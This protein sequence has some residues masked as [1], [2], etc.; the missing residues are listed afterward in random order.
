MVTDEALRARHLALAAERPDASLAATLAAAGA[1]A[2]TRGAITDAVELAEHA[3][4]LT[5]ETTAERPDRLLALAEYLEIAGEYP[6]LAELLTGHADELP[7]GAPRA[8]SHLLLGKISEDLATHEAHLEHAWTESEGEPAL[9]AIVLATKS[10]MLLTRIERIRE[11]DA[12]AV[13]A[14]RLAGSE[15]YALYAL[16]WC[17]LARGRSLDD[18]TPRVPAAKYLESLDRLGALRL[19]FR[20]EVVHARATFARLLSRADERGEAESYA[21]LHLQLCELE[22]R[23]GECKAASGLLARW[24]EPSG[25]WARKRARCEALLAAIRGPAD[26]AEALASAAIA[27]SQA[28]E[29]RWDLL[30]S[31]RARGIAALLKHEPA[32]AAENLRAVWEHTRRE[33]VDDPGVFPVAADLV[34]AIAE[35][36]ELEEALAVTARLRELAEEQEHPWGLAT[37]TRC[38]AQLRLVADRYEQSAAETMAAAADR[39]ERLGLRF[40]QAR[41]LLALGRLQR[42]H[43]KWAAARGSLEGARAAFAEIGASGWAEEARSELDRVGGRR[44][45]GAGELTPS[46]RRVAELAAAGLANKEIARTLSIAVHTVELHLS[47]AYAKLGVRS[48]SQLASR[49]DARV[50]P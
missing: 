15:P 1:H 49:L 26:E 18:V 32:R 45:S 17:R 20:G 12:W 25:R 30:E 19:A 31:L 38:E 24:P 46:E 28:P 16:G 4:R 29:H 41:T 6:R 48:R 23:A 44:P 5:P 43:R 2:R 13:E 11:A 22:L 39:Y 3:L 21:V 33:G 40:D 50:P 9:R 8:R 7:A 47:H 37:A 42:R 34:E 14:H 10:D 36:G 27:A 35:L